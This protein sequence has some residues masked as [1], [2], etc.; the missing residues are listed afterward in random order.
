M[1]LSTN[2]NEHRAGTLQ[3]VLLLLPITMAVM[4]LVV[5]SPVLP[6]MQAHFRDTPGV[7]YLVPLAL[8]A[9]ALCLA[10]LSPLAGAVVDWVGRRRTLMV[11][12]VLY[13]GA[14]VMPLFL[15]DLVAII[16]SRFFLGIM[17]AA[18]VTS[19]TTLI[20]D[21]FHGKER[22]KWLA[23]QTALASVSAV[24][25]FMIGGALGNLGWRAPFMVYTVSLVY[26]VGL[27]LWTWEPQKSEQPK[28]EISGPAA[29]FPW[30]SILPLCV[31][32]AYGGIMFFVMQI[33]LSYLL[34][35]HYGINSPSTIGLYIAIASLT[36]PVGTLVY[37]RIAK[38]PPSLQLLVAF[39]LLGGSFVMLNHA[40]TTT[41]LMVYLVINQLG[42][43]ILLP[44]MAVW[45]MGR[46]PFEIRGRGTGLFMTGWWM[47]QFLSP[48]AV[49]LLRKY[50]G[51]LPAAL[52]ILGILCLVTAVIALLIGYRSRLRAQPSAAERG[53]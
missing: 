34:T 22:E 39:A 37:R 30:A 38:H 7:E 15:D 6:A 13:A 16:V 29:R 35:E 53:A 8:T 28:A 52:Q 9:P 27:L 49:T 41:S 40:P 43:G 23:Y 18:I 44:T 14:G 47:G 24:F 21:Y 20:G 1:S 36:V 17:E 42:C 46:L 12:L 3:G 51:D 19:S 4:G 26:V 45:V 5:L 50:T 32:A 48:Q 25:L 33:Q 11:A 2:V 10:L 31:L